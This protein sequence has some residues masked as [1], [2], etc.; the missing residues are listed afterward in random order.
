MFEF[1]LSPISISNIEKS[2]GLSFSEILNISDED[3]EKLES[4]LTFSKKRDLRK[5][6]RGNPLLSRHKIRTIEDV[7]KKLKRIK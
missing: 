1:S 6:G 4:K 3:K 7:E 2:V 5:I